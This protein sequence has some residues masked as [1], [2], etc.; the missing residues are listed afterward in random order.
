[1]APTICLN[2]IV[3]DESPIIEK[4]LTMLCSKIK[5]DYWVISD[6]GSTDKTPEIITDFFKKNNIPGELKHDKWKNFAHNRNL[7]LNYAF[8]KTDLLLVFDADDDIVGDIPLP[9]T[10]D[11]DGYTTQF[12]DS[13]G[14]SYSRTTL[15]NNRKKW[16]YRSVLHEYLVCLE[17]NAKQQDLKGNYY[18]ISGRTGNRNLNPNKYYDDAI[19]LENAHKEALVTKDPLH[20]RYAFYCANSY[21][22]CQRWADAIK[23]YKIVLEQDNWAQEKYVSCLYLHTCYTNLNRIEYGLYYLVEGIKYDRTRVEGVYLLIEHY[24]QKQDYLMAYNYYKNIQEFYENEYLKCQYHSQQLFLQNLPGALLLPFYMIVVVDRIKKDNNDMPMYVVI[25]KMYEIVFTKKCFYNNETIIK[26]LLFNL[27]FFIHRCIQINPNFVALFQ[28][29]VDFLVGVK[30]P[31]IKY[32][33][34]MDKYEKYGIKLHY[35]EKDTKL[36][37]T[38]DEC[39]QSKKILVFG[40][41]SDIEWNYTY[42]QQFALGGS[43]TAINCLVKEL[44]INNLSNDYEFYIGGQVKEE[45]VG[46]IRY[47]NL[48]TLKRM[49]HEV[50]F[51]TIIVSRYLGF[52][53]MFPDTSFYQ[54]FIWAHDT[55]LN[56]YG[57]NVDVEYILNQ[58]T[59]KISGCICLTNWHKNVFL[60]KYPMLKD[61]INIINNGIVTEKFTYPCK[62]ISNSFIYSSCTE[63]GL[64]KVFELWEKILELLPDAT[65]MIST[66]NPFPRDKNEEKMKQIIDS[67][68]SIKHLGKLNRDQLYELM[69]TSEYWLY[70]TCWPETS[71]ITAMEMLMSEVVC[72]YYPVAGLVDT[73]NNNGIQIKDGNEIETIMN[74]TIDKKNEIKQKGKEYALSCSWENRAKVWNEFIFKLCENKK[75]IGIKNVAIFN[76]FHFHYEM[77]GYIIHLC[78]TCNYT[79]TIFTNMTHNMG[80]LDFYKK[81]FIN[82]E[83]TYIDFKEFN[84]YKDNY[85]LVF[86]TT[87]DDPLFDNTFI[88]DKYI[89]IDHDFIVR[90]PQFKDLRIATRPFSQNLRDWVLPCFP[91]LK[92]TDKIFDETIINIAIVGGCR[93]NYTLLNRLHSDNTIQLHVIGRDVANFTTQ[94]INNKNHNVHLYANLD[95]T[96]MIEMLKKCDYLLTD[97]TT[98]DKHRK[99]K[100][101]SGNTPLAFSTLTPLIIDKYNNSL[102]K[103]KNVIEFDYDA[104][105]K[106]IINKSMIDLNLLDA[107]REELVSMLP[108]WLNKKNFTHINDLSL[109]NLDI[110]LN[111]ALIVEPRDLLGLDEII[112]DTHKKLGN[113]WKIV[114]Y[115]GKGLKRKWSNALPN[116]IND[117]TIDIIELDCNNLTANEYNKFFKQTELYEKLYGEYI[118]VFQADTWIKDNKTLPI[119]YF[120]NLNKSYIGSNM[121]YKWDELE[122]FNIKPQCANFNGGL[123]LRKR[124]DMVRII[125]YFTKEYNGKKHFEIMNY[126][127]DVFFTIGCYMLNLP[128]GDDEAC[129]NFSNH[130]YLTDDCFGVHY[131]T[132]MDPNI[133]LKKY[134]EIYNQRYIIKN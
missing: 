36:S 126:G 55:S 52:Y 25:Q 110:D 60:T 42:G 3:K 116:L 64:Q 10:V 48:D 111:T 67:Y 109:L 79:L 50:P 132:Y 103:F 29:Y 13:N 113:K 17:P 90:R 87:D 80:W 46:N 14:P 26:N 69:S 124:K 43:E 98:I 83:I 96:D 30:F 20:Q 68:P 106:I 57:C 7:A 104:T 6:T 88:T 39:R 118:L 16:E 85:D 71:C 128:I 41:F 27:Q 62:K 49:T 94:N 123:S 107:E 78:K 58:W 33:E 4:T 92:I 44:G 19:V 11:F 127:E 23:W 122:V 34:I 61:K 38:I 97:A 15:I 131:C 102:Y 114:F 95:T 9:N 72:L 117:N 66:Y 65:L 108:E 115:C 75:P 120:I 56:S 81:H 37:F 32:N 63:R 76:S 93:Y 77:F 54:S 8:G 86:V 129:N 28:S 1:M 21:R 70:P 73:M 134:P 84:K 121:N 130:S 59:T 53:E 47:V 35:K 105:D 74:L 99:G 2:M 101:M 12:G 125:D 31:L 24:F 18:L 91:L 5:F 89:C 22:D 40:G 133:L 119:D 45:T 100:S 112:I 82:Y 51:H